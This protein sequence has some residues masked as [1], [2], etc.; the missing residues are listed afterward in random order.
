MSAKQRYIVIFVYAGMVL[1]AGQANAAHPYHPFI[2][3]VTDADTG[4]P[5]PLVELRTV[6]KIVYYTDSNGNVAF[7]EPGLM[8][9]G[10]VYF[11]VKAPYGYEELETDAFGYRGRKFNPVPD[12]TAQLT[13]KPKAD[14]GDRPVET[15]RQRF[16]LNHPYNT[17]S[18][19]YKPF[20][21]TVRDAATRR[22]V[23]LVE[24]RTDDDLSYYTDSAGRVAFYEPDL[25]D[26]DVVFHV[27]SYGY[28]SPAAG[29]VT[30]KT[31]SDGTA[32]ITIRRI[33]IAERLYRITGEGIY[34]DSVLLE[35]PVPLANPVLSGKVV[36]QDTVAMTEYNGKLFW[37]WGDTERPA[38]PLGNFKTSSATSLLSGKGGLDPDVGVDLTYYVDKDGFSKP[39]FPY[40]KANLVWMGT[41]VSV[42][43]NGTECLLASY[44]ARDGNQ[45]FFESGIAVFND[46]AKTFKSLVIFQPNHHI[47][48]F[49]QA[50]KKDGYVYVNCPYPTIRI[51]A[52]RETFQ[53][54]EQYEAFTCLM[55]GTGFDGENTR[56]QRDEKNHLVWEW[57]K[58]TSPL[59]DDQWEKLVKAGLAS[60]QEAW[61]WVRDTQTGK[62]VKLACGSSEYNP[63]KNCWVMV[64]GEKFGESFLGEI[65]VAAAPA[66]EGPWTKARK[67]VT[68]HSADSVYTFYN[69]AYHP[70]FDQNNGRSIYFE[71][72]YVTT[73]SGNPNPTPRYDYNQM[74]YR[75]N[76]SDRRLAKIWPRK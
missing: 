59:N 21:I 30:L 12:G 9:V 11:R 66:P 60:Q 45:K 54:P 29:G 52:D 67:I 32:D 64:T 41:L 33:N 35:K 53:N 19:T 61:N 39:M 36:G 73:Y 18:G 17:A 42:D 16:R 74:M 15:K 48:P 3:T 63:Y 20:T 40:P 49:G 34:N 27:Q 2:I 25:M 28:L 24:L 68:H 13:L 44:R 14:P 5:V 8:N 65:W 57:K 4:Q 72:T 38:Y 7:Y 46:A 50:Y 75:L 71:G 1:L 47:T 31:T 22:G 43:D 58:N 10:D 70:E 69:V 76:L 62:H 51:R 56:L 55:P 37:L 23:P 6:N 26:K